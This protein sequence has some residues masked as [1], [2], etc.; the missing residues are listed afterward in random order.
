MCPLPVGATVTEQE[1]PVVP[2]HVEAGVVVV[3]TC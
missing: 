2:E 1:V 3:V